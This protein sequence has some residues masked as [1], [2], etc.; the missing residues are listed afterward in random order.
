MFF[1]GLF[2]ALHKL[3]EIVKMGI[4]DLIWKVKRGQA[5]DSSIWRE[6]PLEQWRVA[7]GDDGTID[8]A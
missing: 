6:R 2:V 4:F 8:Q 3:H 5:F 7:R 1:H